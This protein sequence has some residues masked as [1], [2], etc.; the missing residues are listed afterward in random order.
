[1]GKGHTRTADLDTVE[2]F[3]TELEERWGLDPED[4]F[5][6]AGMTLTGAKGRLRATAEAVTRA[7]HV[8]RLAVVRAIYK[9]AANLVEVAS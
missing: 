8:K 7:G 3:A 2:R 1:M 6:V 5:T 9:R 4:S